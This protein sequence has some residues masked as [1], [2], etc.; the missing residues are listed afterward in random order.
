[1][2][3]DRIYTGLKGRCDKINCEGQRGWNSVKVDRLRMKSGA[4]LR[5]IEYFPRV[6]LVMD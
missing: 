1:M 3:L 5:I 4:E 2:N 6:E